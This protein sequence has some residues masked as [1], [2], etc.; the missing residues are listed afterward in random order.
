MKC[1]DPV[2][3]RKVNIGFETRLSFLFFVVVFQS[4]LCGCHG[5]CVWVSVVV[6]AC[7][8]VCNVL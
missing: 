6:C 1:T 2:K 4:D 8:R 5:V 7:V 3:F